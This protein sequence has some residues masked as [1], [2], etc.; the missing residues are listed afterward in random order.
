MSFIMAMTYYRPIGGK[1]T[2]LFLVPIH[3]LIF[4]SFFL[5]FTEVSSQNLVQPRLLLSS[6]DSTQ[7]FY[8]AVHFTIEP[9]WHLYWKNPGDTGLPISVGV[10]VAQPYTTDDNIIFS[11]P[12]YLKDDS[13]VSYIYSNETMLLIPIKPPA[14]SKDLPKFSAQVALKWL[15]CREKCLT[16]GDTLSIRSSEISD[17]AWVAMQQKIE[18]MMP[19]FPKQTADC[20]FHLEES[21]LKKSGDKYRIILKFKEALPNDAVFFP[22]NTQNWV[23]FYDQ[24]AIQGK[25]I[26][27]PAVLRDDKKSID[28]ALNGLL[29]TNDIGYELPITLKK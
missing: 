2:T 29:W 23:I 15:V 14:A 26:E 27:I 17:S 21:C 9:E 11:T 24:I 16:G 10:Q 3:L 13:G 8:L 7:P 4:F 12:H 20:P 28:T 1:Y 5:C 25:R 6:K 22:E 19:H 18:Q